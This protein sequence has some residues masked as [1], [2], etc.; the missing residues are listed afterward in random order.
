MET[1]RKYALLALLSNALI[2]GAAIPITKPALEYITPTQFLM[3]RFMLATLITLPVFIKNVTSRELTSKLFKTILAVEFLNLSYLLLLYFGVDRTSALQSSL[4][5]TT[6]PVVISLMGILFLKET[7]EV[8]EAIGL[9]ISLAGSALLVLYPF[10]SS[11]TAQEE[12]SVLGTMLIVASIFCSALY[13]YFVKTKYTHV[14]STLT[15]SVT[16]PFGFMYFLIASLLVSTPTFTTNQLSTGSVLFAIFYMGIFSTPIALGLRNYG[17]KRIEAS[18][19]TLIDYL[20][21]LVY[22]PLS[23]IWLGNTLH[24]FQVIALILIIAGVFMAEY[25]F[26]GNKVLKKPLNGYLFR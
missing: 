21:P 23:I 19:A 18:E 6:R 20:Q 1:A 14:S 13:M 17:F 5:T 7:E 16:A 2:W 11:T 12:I 24:L 22:I 15:Q 26:K 4:L 25:R 9:V 10:F 3:V 8:H